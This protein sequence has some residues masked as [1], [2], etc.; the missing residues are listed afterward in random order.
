MRHLLIVVFW[1]LRSLSTFLLNIT[2]FGA[3]SYS[4]LLTYLF[5][6][7][8]LTERCITKAGNYLSS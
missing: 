2:V 7:D 4:I 5:L 1:Y 8:T 6:L 3:T